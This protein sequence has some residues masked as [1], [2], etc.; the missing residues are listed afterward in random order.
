M[1]VKNKIIGYAAV[2]EKTVEIMVKAVI[3]AKNETIGDND[4][5]NSKNRS[6]CGGR[7]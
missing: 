3:V 5:G 2:E 1:V 7:K 6:D 4:G